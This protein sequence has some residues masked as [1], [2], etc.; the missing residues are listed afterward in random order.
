MSVMR[1]FLN[2]SLLSVIGLGGRPTDYPTEEEF[3]TL[4][5]LNEM[6]RTGFE[7]W[8]RYFPPNEIPLKWDCRLWR[9]SR[10]HSM[11]MANNDFFSHTGSNESTPGDRARA[12]GASF[13]GENISSG[14]ED[15]ETPMRRWGESGLGHCPIMMNPDARSIGAGYAFNA[16][17]SYWSYW[18]LLVSADLPD[19][20]E[21]VDCLMDDGTLPKP[22]PTPMPTP[23]PT[24]ETASAVDHRYSDF[25]VSSWEYEVLHHINEARRI[26]NSEECYGKFYKDLEPLE[27]NC[28]LFKAAREHMQDRWDHRATERWG[29]TGINGESFAD[30]AGKY[31]VPYSCSGFILKDDRDIDYWST[32]ERIVQRIISLACWAVFEGTSVRSK[33]IGTAFA[34]TSDAADKGNFPHRAWILIFNN[35]KTPENLKRSCGSHEAPPVP[36]PTPAPVETY[37][38]PAP[39]NEPTL[40]PTPAPT[41]FPTPAPSLTPVAEPTPAPV[42][43]SMPPTDPEEPSMPPTNPPTEGVMK[44]KEYTE[45]KACR[46]TDVNC[47]WKGSACKEKTSICPKQK[48]EA[49]CFKFGCNWDVDQEICGWVTVNE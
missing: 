22:L 29:R 15:A 16:L 48:T 14:Y 44:C 33:S 24:L 5:I 11:D 39:T 41:P 2:I 8:G 7:C 37:P 45:K 31:G 26:G 4:A 12:Q 21:A 35:H 13:T 34:R 32:P 43:P 6:R 23:V 9:A 36:R 28:G 3:K 18:T 20:P 47:C 42:E 27:W 17:S 19:T 25:E 40:A 38:T 30:R 49:K 46:K 1:C 10:G